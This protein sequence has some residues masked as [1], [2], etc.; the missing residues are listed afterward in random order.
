M[1]AVYRSDAGWQ[2]RGEDIRADAAIVSTSPPSSPPYD[3]MP[4][5]SAAVSPGKI[6]VPPIVVGGVILSGLTSAFVDGVEHPSALLD[7]HE[8]PAATRRTA[9]CHA[10]VWSDHRNLWFLVANLYKVSSRNGKET[11]IGSY[12]NTFRMDV[13]NP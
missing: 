2:E 3:C 5:E 8:R 4:A 13:T 12:H 11:L 6:I 9:R 7:V 1:H 10:G